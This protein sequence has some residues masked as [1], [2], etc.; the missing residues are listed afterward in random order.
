MH[1]V[2]GKIGSTSSCM[3]VTLYKSQFK[4]RGMMELCC[5]LKKKKIKEDIF[6]KIKFKM[7]PEP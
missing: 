3:S 6:K 4:S 1:G 7:S 2:G 5:R